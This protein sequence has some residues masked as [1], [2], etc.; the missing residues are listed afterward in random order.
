M[1]G[2]DG[3]I[4]KKT[5]ILNSGSSIQQGK[6]LYYKRST[7][8]REACSICY[9][10][11]LDLLEMGIE[12][13]DHLLLSGSGASIVVSTVSS[14]DMH[15][16][17]A[18]IPDGPYANFIIP[19]STQSTGAPDFKGIMITGEQT[20]DPVQ[21]IWY[22]VEQLGGLRCDIP[23]Q[24]QNV[25]GNGDYTV[26][27]VP[28]PLCGCLCDDIEVV[29]K[30]NCIV[31]VN[32]CC[33]L[34]KDKFF[35]DDRI[36]NPIQ[37]TGHGWDTISFQQA[38]EQ[39]ARIFSKASRPLL[40][41]WSNTTTEAQILGI[42]IAEQ[43]G[44]IVDNCSSECHGPSIIAIQEVG[45]PGCTL[46]QLKNRA[47]VVVY[48]GC[49]P[50]ES[51]PR[52]MSRYSAF[53][54]GRFVSGGLHKRT[55]IVVDVRRTETAKLADYF[56]RVE[57]NS[58]YAVFSA[59]RALIRGK[60]SVLPETV[61][62]VSVHKLRHIADI[63]KNSHFCSV[64]TGIGLTQSKGKYKN[65]RAAIEFVD[66]VNRHTKCTLTPMRG[67][68][69][70]YGTN[71][72]STFMTGY[73]YAV[74]FSRGIAYYNPGET[75]AIDIIR[76]KECDACLIIG[77]DVGAHFPAECLIHLAHIPT[78]VMDPFVTISTGISRIHIPVAVSGIEVEGTGY[79]MDAVPI[80]VKKV[81]ESSLPTD[82]EILSQV[83]TRIKEL[84]Q[85]ELLPDVIVKIPACQEPSPV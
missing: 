54:D 61:G 71:Q 12:D 31:S 66:E 38:I 11:P 36:F 44:G 33:D 76:R 19:A 56:I 79:R 45:H 32:N 42:E 2:R 48:W 63:C 4:A 43:I 51:H 70:V 20:F 67:H 46:G 15:P 17:E 3:M 35:A 25:Q 72:T 40:F 26:S 81:V 29:V 39:F 83:L 62:G 22:L 58:D 77:T 64:F 13:G 9:I 53:P 85:E 57:P 50:I 73:P 34:G 1:T 55:I 49:N 16:G 69:N 8:Y 24:S 82:E 80:M 37:R 21:P 60:G 78:I 6:G 59:L 5:F 30:E 28:C 10:H 65:V 74:D 18:F 41:G 47:D 7:A 23:K 27:D 84:R 75:S 52:H 68:W 14:D